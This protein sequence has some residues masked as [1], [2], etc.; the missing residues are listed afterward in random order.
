MCS[1]AALVKM[2]LQVNL[3]N[4][5]LGCG[6]LR[7]GSPLDLWDPRWIRGWRRYLSQ[8]HDKP[9][10]PGTLVEICRL[11]KY[12]PFSRMKEGAGES[13]VDWLIFN[14]IVWN[15]PLFNVLIY[16]SVAIECLVMSQ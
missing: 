13:I 10:R 15:T 14:Y 6:C 8:D 4:L 7:W 16:G 11:Q 3:V 12:A 2:F 1:C 9:S 5:I